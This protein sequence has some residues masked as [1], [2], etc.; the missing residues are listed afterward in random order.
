MLG[1][2]P[3]VCRIFITKNKTSVFFVVANTSGKP[4]IHYCNSNYI[5]LK[6]RVGSKLIVQTDC[7]LCFSVCM[8]AYVA[9]MQTCTCYS[10]QVGGSEDNL[11]ESV[12]HFCKD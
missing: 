5:V 11:Q 12:L 2:C 4:S 6:N 1:L 3:G 10:I 8:C 7:F 9:C